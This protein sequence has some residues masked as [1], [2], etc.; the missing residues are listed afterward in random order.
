M[1]LGPVEPPAQCRW[2]LHAD[3]QGGAPGLAP[4]T[5]RGSGWDSLSSRGH[6][7]LGPSSGPTSPASPHRSPQRSPG[8]GGKQVLVPRGPAGDGH[9]H[10]H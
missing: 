2:D 10:A 9:T 6:R 1:T 7:A 5:G 4:H 3:T 8:L